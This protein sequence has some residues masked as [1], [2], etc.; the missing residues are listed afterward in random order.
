MADLESK[1]M[2]VSRVD[3]FVRCYAKYNNIT[4][5][6][7]EAGYAHNTARRTGKQLLE[8]VDVQ[9]K[10]EIER[11]RLRGILDVSD[12]RVVAEIAAIGF[13]NICEVFNDDGSL[14]PIN[15]LSEASQRAIKTLK[16]KVTEEIT[17]SSERITQQIVTIEMH[18]KLPA[19]QQL[20]AIKGLGDG[21]KN[22]EV[23]VKVDIKGLNG[24]K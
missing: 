8:R 13:G 24:T 2:Q 6:A 10:L 19:L 7:L 11:K 18:P 9:L 4:Y 15:E 3:R 14:K 22:K 17:E 16:V 5:A 12:K 23:K 20:V 1:Q 21:E